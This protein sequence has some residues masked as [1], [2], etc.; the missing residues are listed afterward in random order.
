MRNVYT[1]VDIHR[2][3]Y[4]L[5]L[6]IYLGE[7]I[8]KLGKG[9]I[10]IRLREVFLKILEMQAFLMIITLKAMRVYPSFNVCIVLY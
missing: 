9:F 10:V 6:L 4:F 7:E 2:E 3:C 8:N 5:S 1:C